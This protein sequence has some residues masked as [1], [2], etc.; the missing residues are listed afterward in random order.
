MQSLGTSQTA[1]ELVH[2]AVV[3]KVRPGREAEFEAE[4]AR[5]F[6]AAAEAG[7]NG[8][9]LIRPI[10]GTRSREYGILR[11]FR[12]RE[13]MKRF[14]ASDLYR[15]W[16]ETSGSL[17]EGAPNRRELHGLDIFFQE[18]GK[19]PPRWK[20]AIVTYLAVTPAVYV[21][22]RLV[23]ALFDGLPGPVAMLVVNICV[24]ASLTWILM[25]LLIK[26]FG[27]WLQAKKNDP[28]S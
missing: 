19:T 9:Y 8:A 25:P 23:P 11:A 16:S 4:I 14:Y 5:F 22:S 3:R 6:G 2:V 28:D 12:N 20:M 1:Q 18:P 21:F 24:V 26:A 10:L 13:E 15:Q 27:R 7:A 17:V